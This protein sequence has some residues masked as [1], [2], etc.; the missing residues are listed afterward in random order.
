MKN[1]VLY[2]FCFLFFTGCVSR[3]KYVALQKQREQTLIDKT[4]LEEVLNK[5]VVEND[6]LKKQ[7]NILDSAYRADHE[8]FIALSIKNNSPTPAVK[9]KG[10][11]MPKNV[12]YEKK[13]LYVYNLPYYIFWPKNSKATNFL[14]GIVGDSPMNAA[15]ALHVYGKN[16]NELP[17][18]VEPY[19]PAP[20]KFYHMIF[21]AESRNKDFYKLKKELKN[22]PVLLIVE[23]RHLEKLGAHI[24][25]YTEGDK[26]RFT[27][28]KKHIERTGLNVSE[29]LIKLSN[30]N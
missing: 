20:G 10:A 16:I 6:S 27:V 14:I 30:D 18:V 5:V 4:A 17:A 8:K 15:L 9:T 24:S 21:I 11:A 29:Q 3:Q 23:N 13:A 28:N 26:I 22:Q 25:F 19:N 7:N 2:I 12:E 1:Y